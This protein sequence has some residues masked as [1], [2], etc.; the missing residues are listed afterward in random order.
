MKHNRI[1]VA[2]TVRDDPNPRFLL[3]Y[4][5]RYLW[6]CF[7]IFGVSSIEDLSCPMSI[8]VAAWNL[9]G[10]DKTKNKFGSVKLRNTGF[11]LPNLESFKSES[12][13]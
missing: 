7:G 4:A 3:Q 11:A 2:V 1:V 6:S 5:T 10:F 12:F 9:N 8:I 13:V